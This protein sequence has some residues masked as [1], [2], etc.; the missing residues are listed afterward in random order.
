MRIDSARMRMLICA[1]AIATL[2]AAGAGRADGATTEI[3]AVTEVRSAA[4]PSATAS[5]G[6]TVQI[7]E[8]GGSYAVPPGFSTITSWTHSTGG[9]AGSLTFKVYRPTGATRE[10]LT[11]ASDTQTVVANTVMTFGVKI[12]VQPG[13]RIGLSSDDVELAYETFDEADRIGFF[14]ADPSPG[15]T[16]ATDGE[17]FGEFKLDVVAT[18]DSDPDAGPALPPPPPPPPPAAAGGPRPTVRGLTLA[19]RAFRA[20]RSGPSTMPA[21]SAPSG[22]RVRYFVAVAARVRFT[23]R[24]QRPGRRIGRGSAARCATPTRANRAA[25]RCTRSVALP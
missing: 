7:A 5:G 20:A 25:P 1:T 12:A 22:T 13:D 16:R 17:P 3:G 23:V 18:L 19:P 8:A 15:T 2:L 9:T 10:F 24:A 4:K 6:F 14:G 11:I 21:L